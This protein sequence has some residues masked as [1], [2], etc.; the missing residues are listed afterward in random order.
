[1][2]QLKSLDSSLSKLDFY[3][4]PSLLTLFWPLW[5]SALFSLRVSWMIFCS[6]LW[7]SSYR[8]SIVRRI[9]ESF[10]YFC[11]MLESWLLLLLLSFVWA[12][13]CCSIFLDSAE[14]S[15]LSTIIYSFFWSWKLLISRSISFCFFSSCCRSCLSFSLDWF[16][17]LNFIIKSS[18]SVKYSGLLLTTFWR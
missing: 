15:L 5:F 4:L 11:S 17:I 18:I 7:T 16:R 1:M 13:S 2:Y 12:S 9:F 8:L 10:S 3:F 14:I 6:W